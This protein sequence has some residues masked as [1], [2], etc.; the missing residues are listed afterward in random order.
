VGEDGDAVG[1]N[2]VGIAFPKEISPLQKGDVHFT[3]WADIISKT[4]SFP[5]TMTARTTAV[6][7]QIEH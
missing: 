4:T 3:Q 2:R 6:P 5:Q 1:A 7:E